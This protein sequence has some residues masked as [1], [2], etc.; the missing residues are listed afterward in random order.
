[1]TR[2]P[3]GSNEY[4][5]SMHL[6]SHRPVRRTAARPEVCAQLLGEHIR[7]ARL[8]DGR[9]LEEIAPLAALTVP[10][11]EAIEAGQVPDT[12]EQV[13]LIAAALHIG[14]TWMAWLVKLYAG[15]GK[16]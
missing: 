12:W 11:W 16:K 2:C 6:P 8:R 5:S 13:C 9:P 4:I 3:F 15:A 14:R 1:M 10:E 7:T